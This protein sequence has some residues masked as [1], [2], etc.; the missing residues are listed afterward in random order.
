[1]IE[2]LGKWGP[3]RQRV[4]LVRRDGR[5]IV[6]WYEA[7]LRREKSWPDAKGNVAIAR[8]WAKTFSDERTLPTKE[9]PRVLTMRELWELYQTANWSSLA[10][11]SQRLYGDAW[12]QWELF[13]GRQL[14]PE[15]VTPE[16]LHRFRRHLELRKLG[17][18]SI[19][20]IVKTCKVVY[21]WA[22]REELIQRNRWRLFKYK[23]AKKDKPKSPDEYSQ[24][25]V[26][27]ML[28]HVN[29]QRAWR[30]WVCLTILS[31]QGVRQVSAL[32]MKWADL[33]LS[34]RSI[35]WPAE[36]DK[37]GRPLVQP[38]RKATVGALRWA[39]DRARGLGFESP[40]VLPAN[41]GKKGKP[42][43]LPYY[44]PQS[45]WSA[46]TNA[47]E[48][49]GVPHRKGRAAHGLRRKMVGDLTRAAGGDTLGA[50]RMV[51]DR[52]PRMAEHYRKDRPGEVREAFRKLERGV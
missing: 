41:Q 28:P 8:A 49:A 6:E 20:Q 50:L 33:R 51:G 22:E 21:N 44:T 7:R 23:V 34:S 1:M 38:L 46:L 35:L 47:E 11:N 3:S 13:A 10:P 39:R 24:D 30:A 37:N 36:T 12:K 14:R 45:L 31:Q 29:R 42:P 16:L 2:L 19:A 32:Q 18:N 25:E 48:R 40:Y 26:D 15:D 17:V 52:D 27:R 9:A 43:K 4:R 5:L